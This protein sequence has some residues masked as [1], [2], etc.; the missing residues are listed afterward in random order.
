MNATA[1]FSNGSSFR[2]DT[3]LRTL[4]PA[5]QCARSR[6]HSAGTDSESFVDQTYKLNSTYLAVHAEPYH[7]RTLR[8]R[9][10]H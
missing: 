7:A 10:S 5:T 1:S 2:T 3:G 8:F 4:S 6:A 9:G